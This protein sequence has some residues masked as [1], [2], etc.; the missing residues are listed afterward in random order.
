MNPD[1][2]TIYVANFRSNTVS[3]IDGLTNLVEANITLGGRPDSDVAGI[4][5]AN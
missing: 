5:L 4:G 1:T 2:N 3:V